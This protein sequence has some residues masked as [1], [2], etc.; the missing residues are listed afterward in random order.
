MLKKL[1]SLI[2][3]T[4]LLSGCVLFLPLTDSLDGG[5][6]YCKKHDV[7]WHTQWNETHNCKEGSVIRRDGVE[8]RR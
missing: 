8:I 2:S 5:Y 7:Y 6:R 3:I 1:L 4:I